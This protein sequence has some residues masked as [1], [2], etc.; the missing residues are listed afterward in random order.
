M[1]VL[2]TGQNG[3]LGQELAEELRSH[4]YEV[5]SIGRSEVDL[6][7][8]KSVKDYFKGKQFD[9]VVHTAFQGGKKG[10]VD[11]LDSFINNLDMF[12]NLVKHK[13]CYSKLINFCSG[14]AF[15]R[16][17]EVYEYNEEQYL[18]CLP[19]DY[20][21]MSKNIISRECS[22]LENVYN[23]RI[24]GCFGWQEN[25]TRFIKSSIS[26]SL[27]GE[28]IVIH[29]DRMID[30]IS[31][32]DIASVVHFYITKQVKKQYE[33]VNLCYPQRMTLRKLALK[34]IDLTKSSS[35]I[36]IEKPGL[37]PSYTGSNRK[38]EQLGIKLNGLE[39]ELKNLVEKMNG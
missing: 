12:N 15:D 17:R 7:D 23:L 10:Q 26:K 19:N 30:F 32:K 11:K 6:T 36:I 18:E 1:K 29:Q 38:L 31:T 28:P 33:D 35:Q 39:Q 3:F 27:K 14:A 24:F 20:Y 22:K 5:T 9:V 4:Y 13:E 37:S 21:G 34:I 2:I 16:N 8:F 25:E